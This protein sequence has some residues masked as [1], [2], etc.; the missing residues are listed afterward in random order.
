[1]DGV[2]ETRLSVLVVPSVLVTLTV[3]SWVLLLLKVALEGEDMG[4]DSNVLLLLGPAAVLRPTFSRPVDDV[5]VGGAV[6]VASMR[7]TSVLVAASLST[8]SV[9]VTVCS[10]PQGESDSSLRHR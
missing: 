4:W 8:V 10:T 9:T 3:A 5:S 1:M 7:L 2:A 6:L